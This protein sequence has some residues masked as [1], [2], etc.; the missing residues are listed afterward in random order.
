V[1][2]VASLALAATSCA[3]VAEVTAGVAR[4][5]RSATQAPA[6]EPPQTELGSDRSELPERFPEAAWLPITE[7]L[8]SLNL[9]VE[10]EARGVKVPALLDTGAYRVFMSKPVAASLGIDELEIA[11][12]ARSEVRDAHGESA[13]A[14]TI[15]LG[16]LAIG[17]HRWGSVA[18]T[19]SGDIPGIFL[20]GLEVL[21]DVDLYV[22]ADEGLVGVFD[23]G[24][25]PSGGGDVIAIT[26]EPYEVFVDADVPGRDGAPVR[27]LLEVDTGHWNTRFPIVVGTRA[28]VATDLRFAGDTIGAVSRDHSRGRF[29][30]D[31]LS[32]GAH[33][34]PVGRVYAWGAAFGGG[35]SYGLLGNDVFMRFHSIL[36]LKDEQLV[37]RP[38]PR[39]PNHRTRGP[40]GATCQA[41]DGQA[42]PCLRVELAAP[43]R[44]VPDWARED[45]CLHVDIEPAW[46]G[47]TL[48]LAV[49]ATTPDG[50]NVFSGGAL[51][52]YV[53]VPPA[54]F[55]DCHAIHR[56]TEVSGLNAE[57]AISLQR[58]RAEG[59]EWPCNPEWI[60]C[61]WSS[62][63]ISIVETRDDG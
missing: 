37:L 24:G 25:A 20:I 51:R 61:S 14:W 52:M 18:A 13:P 58:V 34:V 5:V 11:R 22:A 39:R 33:R 40:G 6:R 23:S 44:A 3:R 63:P 16:E 4:S 2:V 46:A 42:V 31:P 30:L 38:L 19:V 9:A 48:E 53:S 15:D 56:G 55:D 26:R 54:G 50:K 62:G 45:L 29:V 7:P 28:G 27:V 8:L 49:I 1:S 60:W 10:V 41:D 21:Q 57:S 35:E 12:G 43:K 47:K 32:L 17:H 59:F 36:R